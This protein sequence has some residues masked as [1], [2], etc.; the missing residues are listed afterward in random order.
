LALILGKLGIVHILMGGQILVMRTVM[1]L[2][3]TLYQCFF[4]E[5]SVLEGKVY[6]VLVIRAFV[7]S[8]IWCIPWQFRPSCCQHRAS[9]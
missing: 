9:A 6:L 2:L 5:P 1:Q 8:S 7:L 4:T 3:L